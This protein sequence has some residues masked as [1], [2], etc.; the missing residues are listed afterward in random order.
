MGVARMTTHLLPEF[1][2]LVLEPSERG[3]TIVAS[4]ETAL[5]IPRDVTR[6]I[7]A[8]EVKFDAPQVRFLCGDVVQ[9]AIMWVRASVGRPYVEDVI[10]VLVVRAGEIE[11]VDWV[12]AL[13]M[14][15]AR[16]PLRQLLG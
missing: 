13:S 12:A 5:A 6:Q 7:H 9:E 8:G 16:M 14:V 10:R 4:D 2:E 11:Q 1:E 3:L 15:R